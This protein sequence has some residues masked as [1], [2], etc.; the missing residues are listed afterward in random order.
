MCFQVISE[1]YHAVQV[2]PETIEDMAASLDLTEYTLWNGGMNIAHMMAQM[3][4]RPELQYMVEGRRNTSVT[5]P[6]QPKR[7]RFAAFKFFNEKGLVG[8]DFHRTL[9]VQIRELDFARLYYGHIPPTVW[10]A[11]TNHDWRMSPMLRPTA[12]QRIRFEMMTFVENNFNEIYD[13]M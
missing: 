8:D 1:A 6:W 5:N 4:D 9:N 12:E 7:F 10:A 3:L 2:N 11:T 13:R